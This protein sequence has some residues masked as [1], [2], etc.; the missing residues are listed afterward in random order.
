MSTE[1]THTGMSTARKAGVAAAVLVGAAALIFIF[2][3]SEEVNVE[4]LGLEIR[5]PLFLI[6]ILSGLTAVGLRDLIGWTLRR[7]RT[8]AERRRTAAQTEVRGEDE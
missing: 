1:T 5:A 2:Q 8:M 6:M 7:R 3:N 4:W